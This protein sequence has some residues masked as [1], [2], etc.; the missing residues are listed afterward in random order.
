MVKQRENYKFII[1]EPAKTRIEKKLCPI[2]C[3]PKNDWTRRKDWTCCSV[4]CTDQFKKEYVIFGWQDL[5]SR[6]FKRD[7]WSCVKCG[8][9]PKKETTNSITIYDKVFETK[10]VLASEHYGIRYNCYYGPEKRITLKV[11]SCDLIGDHI[12]P[13]ALGGDEWEINNIQTLCLECNKI[14][15]A[16]DA[17]DIARLRDIEK[18]RKGNTTLV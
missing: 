16:Q 11:I 12:I 5:R 15:T 3:K 4:E 9:Q 7:N 8:K 18:K 17:K 2:C 14:K 1:L 6:A 10:E 13:I